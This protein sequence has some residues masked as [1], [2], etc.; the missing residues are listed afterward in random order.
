MG[1]GPRR[2]GPTL[3]TRSSPLL[4]AATQAVYAFYIIHQTVTIVTVY[5]LLPCSASYWVKL[6]IV[7]AATVLVT[8]ASYEVIRHVGW[9]RPLFGLRRLDHPMAAL[10]SGPANEVRRVWVA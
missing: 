2:L 7:I 8:W 1:P 6:P 4:Q 10:S 3:I 5:L 9:L